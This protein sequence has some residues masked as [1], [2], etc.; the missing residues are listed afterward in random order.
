MRSNF[1][2]QLFQPGNGL[3][4]V[5]GARSTAKRSSWLVLGLLLPLGAA[6][7]EPS[8]IIAS[9]S[10]VGDGWISRGMIVDSDAMIVEMIA[11]FEDAARVLA[12][13][14]AV[15]DADGAILTAGWSYGIRRDGAAFVSLQGNQFETPGIPEI[16]W[17]IPPGIEPEEPNI[18]TLRWT[19]WSCA[20]GPPNPPALT[21]VFFAGGGITTWSYEVYANSG[22]AGQAASG[23]TTFSKLSEDFDHSQGTYA[24]VSLP[25]AT[26]QVQDDLRLDILAEDPIFAVYESGDE[27]GMWVN[28]PSESLPCPCYLASDPGLYSFHIDRVSAAAPTVP[29]G[30]LRD[31]GEVVLFGFSAPIPSINR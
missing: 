29:S 17:G 11:E 19:C 26:V 21:L 1:L 25:Y 2:E 14:V 27:H 15:Y 5:I 30:L 23:T 8:N 22:L 3:E 13:G 31:S 10:A 6:L 9:G 12:I 7:A 4:R 18:I 16:N 24:D 20:D 28:T